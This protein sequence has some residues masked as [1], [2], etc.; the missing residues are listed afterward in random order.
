MSKLPILFNLKKYLQSV[1]I[2]AEELGGDTCDLYDTVNILAQAD[3]DS[4]LET[5]YPIFR[6]QDVGRGHKNWIN[7][8]GY[9]ELSKPDDLSISD[10]KMVKDPGKGKL[11]PYEINLIKR[12]VDDYY[13]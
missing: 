3:M 9:I 13:A 11:S 8:L 5:N 2:I 4:L 12:K 7:P 6:T 1:K 10:I